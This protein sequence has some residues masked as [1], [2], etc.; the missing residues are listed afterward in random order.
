M[1]PGAIGTVGGKRAIPILEKRLSRETSDTAKVGFYQALYMLGKHEVRNDI[2]RLSGSK[3]YR[4]RCAVVN[5]L[6]KVIANSSNA[7]KILLFLRR[8]LSEERVSSVKST[9]REVIKDMKRFG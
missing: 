4:V 8:W 3:D 5:I 9:L 6:G 7:Q 1:L 2:L